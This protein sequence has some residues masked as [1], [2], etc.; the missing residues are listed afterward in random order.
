MPNNPDK[1]EI[2]KKYLEE[3]FEEDEKSRE[4]FCKFVDELRRLEFS[5]EA[6]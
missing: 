6:N 5:G 3:F 4:T 2:T 1:I